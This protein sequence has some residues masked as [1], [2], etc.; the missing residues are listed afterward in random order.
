V[1]N[2]AT[3]VWAS[4][5]LT[6]LG[7]CIHRMGPSFRRS[8]FGTPLALLGLTC[9][10]ILPEGNEGPESLLH[11]SLVELISWAVPFSFGVILVLRAAPTY[12]KTR[13]MEMVVGWGSIV[14]SWF[15]LSQYYGSDS[16]SDALLGLW[17]LL[18]II[19]GLLA[20]FAG[21]VLAEKRSGFATETEPLSNEEETL[22]RTILVRRLG[23]NLDGD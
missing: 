5:A 1:F 8:R 11:D 22:V 3:I 12:W 4:L 18:G 7:Y 2:D 23:G 6:I 19:L 10:I 15:V 21:V 16:L 9:L 14:F 20:F 17:A 13:P